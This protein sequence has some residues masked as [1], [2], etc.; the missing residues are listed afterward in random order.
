M[1]IGI[2]VPLMFRNIELLGGISPSEVPKDINLD[3]NISVFLSISSVF[4]TSIWTVNSNSN[5]LTY[6]YRA[7]HNKQPVHVILVSL[8]PTPGKFLSHFHHTW[9]GGGRGWRRWR[10]ARWRS[11]TLPKVFPISPTISC[12]ITDGLWWCFNDRDLPAAGCWSL[13]MTQVWWEIR[14][15]VRAR[16]CD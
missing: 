15:C 5:S 8:K 10:V 9:E 13:L 12:V 3:W 11:A 2:V 1:A 14:V 6:P 4:Q 16:V 7:S